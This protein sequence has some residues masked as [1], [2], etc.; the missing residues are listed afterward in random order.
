MPRHSLP[1]LSALS[2]VLLLAAAA[3]HGSAADVS[4][5]GLL[6]DVR[7]ALG[8]EK[9]LA[10]VTGLSAEGTFRRTFGTREM[11]GDVEIAIELPGRYIRTETFSPSG[12]PGNRMIR[13][14]GFNGEE[15]LDGVAGSGGFMM[16]F[17][18]PGGPGA[19]QGGGTS[20]GRA[21]DPER[22]ARMLRGHRTDVS[23]LL[24][25]M[26]GRSDAIGPLTV[27]YAGEAESSDGKADVLEASLEGGA[28]C[29]L[30][31]DRETHLPLLMTYRE[32]APRM[33]NMQRPPQQPG[34]PAPSREEMEKLFRDARERAEKEPPKTQ[35]VEV[36]FSDHRKVGGVLL[37]HKI[38]RVVDGTPVEETVITGY[39]V[40][41]A[42]KADVFRK[43]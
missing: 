35:E 21:A 14:T 41:P 6:H 10:R 30:F 3:L 39:K 16:R 38:S 4:V 27:T 29:R 23:R 33:L 13:T 7:G 8:G 32:Q 5:D 28:P 12:D 17:G 1:T 22:A 31:I 20:D 2:A 15:S 43:H 26:L 36:F 18:G 40:N 24:L 34:Q 9:A 37:P 42:F 19:G 11:S 25:A